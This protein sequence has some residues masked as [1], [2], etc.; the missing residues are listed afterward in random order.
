MYMAGHPTVAHIGHAWFFFVIL[1]FFNMMR[2]LKFICDFF[3]YC[4]F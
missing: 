3:I 2:F 4:V 1:I